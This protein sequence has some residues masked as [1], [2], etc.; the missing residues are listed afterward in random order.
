LDIWFGCRFDDVNPAEDVP[1][2][3]EN[4]IVI[5]VRAGC[6]SYPWIVIGAIDD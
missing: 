2:A 6:R 3:Q 5:V 1:F 4:S